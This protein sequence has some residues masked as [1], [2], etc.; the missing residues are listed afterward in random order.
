MEYDVAK[1]ANGMLLEPEELREIFE[2]YFENAQEL[3][4]KLHNAKQ[5]KNF[6][7]IAELAHE[8]KGASLNLNLRQAAEFSK[9]LE[10]LAKQSTANGMDSALDR[11]EKE[12]AARQ[13]DVE[14][15]YRNG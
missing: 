14:N 4:D 8:F 5:T 7:A 2:L 10:V 9:Y 6:T 12:I 11:L 3:F 1:E 13:Q 15:F